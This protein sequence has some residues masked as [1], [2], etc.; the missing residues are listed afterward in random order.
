MFCV[1][2]FGK[3][4]FYSLASSL[5][6]SFFFIASVDMSGRGCINIKLCSF[7]VSNT[8]IFP[9][10]MLWLNIFFCLTLSNLYKEFINFWLKNSCLWLFQEFLIGSI[11][12]NDLLQPW[13][14]FPIPFSFTGA[15]YPFNLNLHFNTFITPYPQNQFQFNRTREYENMLQNW[16]D[17]I[18]KGINTEDTQKRARGGRWKS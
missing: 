7:T 9:L 13:V 16:I 4:Y 15:V 3:W 6:P 17:F 2:W 12:C 18:T 1:R 5:T 11:K 8:R 14:K 10:K